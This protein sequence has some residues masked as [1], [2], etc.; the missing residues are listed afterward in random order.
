MA[1]INRWNEQVVSATKEV[2]GKTH[3]F[4]DGTRQSC[5]NK[6][7]NLG[8]L[9]TDA[10]L[11]KSISSPDETEW[12]KIGVVLFNSGGIRHSIEQGIIKEVKQKVE[13]V[14]LVRWFNYFLLKKWILYNSN[15][16]R[17]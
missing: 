14:M 2:I 10:I 5:R 6:E 7:C 12:N 15:M 8:N 17:I 3:V 13:F 11:W 1:E 16:V 4:L 9:L